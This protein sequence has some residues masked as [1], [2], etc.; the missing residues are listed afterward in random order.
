MGR[1]GVKGTSY[2]RLGGDFSGATAPIRM[3]WGTTNGA[4]TTGAHKRGELF[5]DAQGQL[6]LCVADGTPGS[7]KHVH[8]DN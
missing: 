6:F 8:L 4:P 1:A 3:Q 7:W 2:T 5:V